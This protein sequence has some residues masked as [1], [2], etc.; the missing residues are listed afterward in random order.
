M[1]LQS[2]HRGD[3]ESGTPGRCVSRFVKS[4]REPLKSPCPGPRMTFYLWSLEKEQIKEKRKSGL[5]INR[6]ACFFFSRGGVCTT[7]LTG[8]VA[9]LM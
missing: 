8:K 5:K 7:F 9:D 4:E 1:V 3:G 6:D 2:K